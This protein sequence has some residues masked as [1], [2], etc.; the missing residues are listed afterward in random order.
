ME[1]TFVNYE[2]VYCHHC[3]NEICPKCEQ[4]H[5]PHCD[6]FIRCTEEDEFSNP[7]R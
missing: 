5:T 1:P 4:C 7:E 3:W 2:D 6:E